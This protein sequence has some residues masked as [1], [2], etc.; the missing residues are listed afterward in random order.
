MA[1]NLESSFWSRMGLEECHRAICFQTIRETYPQFQV[2]EFEEQGYCSYTLEVSCCEL[3]LKKLIVQIRPLQ[4]PLS[5]NITIAASTTYGSFAP[6]TIPLVVELPSGLHA[7]EMERMTGVAYKRLQPRV[8]SLDAEAIQRQTTLVKSF[9][10]FVAKAWPEL[11]CNTPD[12][13]MRADSP[14]DTSLNSNP[15]LQCTGKVGS[16]IIPKLQKLAQH[17]PSPALRARA[18]KTLYYTKQLQGFPTVLNHGDLI[19]SNILLSPISFEIT[20]VVDWVE[21]ENLPF[22]TCLYGLEHLLGYLDDS[23]ARS[24]KPKWVYYDQESELRSIFWK[25]MFS[26]HGT[27]EISMADLR[28]TRDLG[29]LLWYGYAWDEGAINRVINMEN[30]VEELEIL[31]TFLSVE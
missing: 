3:S 10:S 19:P 1:P 7:F 22:G 4:H 31:E 24:G 18:A 12:R 16:Q 20:G 30:D 9:A 8:S 26:L 28:S 5:V 15:L 29:V 27:M 23:H 21:A 6:S 11:P 14:L 2:R 13:R 17:L 25:E